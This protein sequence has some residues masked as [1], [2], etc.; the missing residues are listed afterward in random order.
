MIHYSTDYVFDGMKSE[1]YTE[2][3][4]PRPINVY[5]SSK[6]AGELAV[7]AADAPYLIFRTSWVY[8]LRGKNFLIT[9]LRL[10][11]EQYELRIVAD[12]FGAPTWSRTIAEA[13]ALALAC[14]C[15]KGIEHVSGV[16]HLI[17]AG[18]VSWCG[19]AEAIVQLSIVRKIQC[20]LKLIRIATADYQQAAS[21]L[22]NSAMSTKKFVAAFDLA[23]PQ[24]NDALELCMDSSALLSSLLCDDTNLSRSTGH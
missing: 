18:F 20:T 9:I 24:W 11:K 23:L 12:Q 4:A 17:A 10:A 3:D 19:F 16:Y 13:T 6:L 22:A 7:Q 21:R 8:G 1:P 15:A 2:D 14:S 5:G